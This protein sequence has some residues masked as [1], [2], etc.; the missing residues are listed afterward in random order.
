MG[1]EQSYLEFLLDPTRLDQH[2]EKLKT[3]Q[4]F[5]PS[6]WDLAKTFV[7]ESVKM[8]DAK[9]ANAYRLEELIHRL[10]RIT[11]ITI[12]DIEK[13]IPIQLQRTMFLSHMN[14]GGIVGELYYHMWII[15]GHIKSI[16][17]RFLFGF[18]DVVHPQEYFKRQ[19]QVEKL[20][21][22]SYSFLE[23]W[24][25]TEVAENVVYILPKVQFE[26]GKLLFFREQFQASQE[27]FEKVKQFVESTQ[28]NIYDV[29]TVVLH[30]FMSINQSILHGDLQE[31]L[32]MKI[33]KILSSESEEILETLLP[34]LLEDMYENELTWAYR[35]QLEDIPKL[36]PILPMIKASNTI[37]NIILE[38][39][40]HER[41]DLEINN[42]I[43]Y[44]SELMRIIS[45]INETWDTDNIYRNYK[46]KL[47]K[48]ELFDTFNELIHRI[49]YTAS[50]QELWQY[51]IENGK[52]YIT[53]YDKQ[54]YSKLY[55]NEQNNMN[56]DFDHPNDYHDKFSNTFL[57][58]QGI[59]SINNLTDYVKNYR[60]FNDME[61][62]LENYKF[63][64]ICTRL[65][66]MILEGEFESVDTLINTVIEN[67]DNIPDN[68]SNILRWKGLISMVCLQKND[69]DANLFEQKFL[70]LVK[71]GK[72]GKTVLIYIFGQLI[73]NLFYETAMVCVGAIEDG[74]QHNIIN[75]EEIL[76]FANGIS[77]LIKLLMQFHQILQQKSEMEIED[78]NDTKRTN[79]IFSEF[80][81]HV[82]STAQAK[83]QNMK[84]GNFVWSHETGILSKITNWGTLVNLSSTF[85]FALSKIIDLADNSKEFVV[86]PFGN[87]A[88]IASEKSYF[89][90]GWWL[91]QSSIKFML[92]LWKEVLSQQRKVDPNDHVSCKGIADYHFYTSEYTPAIKYYLQSAVL[93][94]K[95]WTNME[96]LDTFPKSIPNF[97]VALE[98]TKAY[99]QAVIMCQ[100]SE[101]EPDYKTAFRIVKDHSRN[102]DPSY[103]N[104]LWNMP[105]IEIL[106]Y[107][108]SKIEDNEEIVNTLVEI[109]G[110][111]EM[112]VFSDEQPL[113]A[114]TMK[115]LFYRT[116]YNEMSPE[117]HL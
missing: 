56:E 66:A 92:E 35:N 107:T 62:V 48:S 94:S 53:S 70:E 96:A 31:G 6:I 84:H 77:V 89:G 109:V 81:T 26:I 37:K 86:A 16:S 42:Y 64:N 74:I 108:Q 112:N 22:E 12:E 55:K 76:H 93:E 65:D 5:F 95:F 75:D 49:V 61:N 100:M 88:V 7:E 69:F 98:S 115:Q 33:E 32:L 9:I 28:I 24:S 51:F 111:T 87:I 50:D 14:H 82:I 59:E 45:N 29:D 103:F 105:I 13:N 73:N 104:F 23:D 18:D 44:T 106:V 15:R 97:I 17:N 110:K 63:R 54:I 91:Q 34:I 113:F 114:Q 3:K 78:E 52:E 10:C 41:E 68:Y 39:R 1:R 21:N 36:K 117:H 20:V 19:T 38:D 102:L 67:T 101:P 58:S 43:S 40:I 60:K 83:S 57:V 47:G 25:K 11:K 27:E 71:C 90:S 80:L 99:I 2:W 72:I 46:T 30:T 79:S 4:T 116:Y 8:K 85:A